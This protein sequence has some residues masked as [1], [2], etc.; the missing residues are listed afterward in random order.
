MAKFLIALLVAIFCCL[1]LVDGR[2]GVDLSVE[3]SA[4]TW[5]CLINQHNVTYADVRVSHSTG[6]LD[7]NGPNSIIFASR[8]GLKDIGAY[9][10]PC[11][12]TS[13][14]SLSHN[15][16]CASPEDQVESVVKLL[17]QNL[18]TINQQLLPNA[19]AANVNRIWLDI[20]DESP[21]KYF[22]P[23]VAV[24]QEFLSRMVN[25]LVSHK[26]PVGIYTTKTYWQDIMGNILGY[27][28]YPLWYPRYDGINSFD[29]F[30][31]FAGWE[32][33]QIKQTGGD[34]GWCGI[35]QVDPDYMLDA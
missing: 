4:S 3:T 5:D 24:N 11:I 17:H 16:T 20:E 19:A 23:N 27:A 7:Y 35:S 34:I 30:V 15:I 13:P 33:A 32:S 2:T 9:I 29:F 31:P 8:A 12:T 28:Q 26:S 10:F 14:Y 6:Q 22:D 25:A 21:S 18:I 1:R